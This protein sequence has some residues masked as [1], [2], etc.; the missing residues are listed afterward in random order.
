MRSPEN[1]GELANIVD[2]ACMKLD[3]T[4]PA[5][6]RSAIAETLEKFERIDAVVNNAGYGLLG[7]FEAA[8]D[9]QVRRSLRPTC[10]AS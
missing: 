7:P 1:V 10:S 2:L 5:S 8:S 6:I 9:E 4:D 3:V